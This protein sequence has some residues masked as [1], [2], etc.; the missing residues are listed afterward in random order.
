MSESILWMWDFRTQ[1][2]VLIVLFVFTQGLAAVLCSHGRPGQT[3]PVFRNV[4]EFAMLVPAFICVLLP[5]LFLYGFEMNSFSGNIFPYL[6]IGAIL[7]F[8]IR[9]IRICVLM[10]RELRT[11]LS[12][13]SIKNAVDTL[14]SGVLFCERSGYVLLINAQM[15][16][17]MTVITGKVFRDSNRFYEML[18]AGDVMPGCE[19]NEL[20]NQIVYVLPDDSAWMLTRSEITIKG[21]IYIQITATDIT[22]RWALTEQL[23]RQEEELRQR[24]EEIKDTLANLH[25]LSREKVG[26]RVKM[27]A[28][29]VLGERL[30]L[31]LRAV[32]NRREMDTGMLY[33]L[34]TDFLDEI[35]ASEYRIAPDDALEILK[36]EFALI[37]VE[38]R[39]DG[40]LPG[41]E[42]KSRLS[43]EIIR[44]A[45][46]NAV[47]HGFATKVN[48]HMEDSEAGSCLEITDN[49]HQPTGYKEGGGIGGIRE[50]IK[51]LGGALTI[52]TDPGFILSCSFP[53]LFYKD[54]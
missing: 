6:F 41:D 3:A 13:F 43:L 30:T 16:R 12:A 25:I 50:K 48:I 45:V 53:A 36:Q 34:S 5:G 49:G 14:H 28:H 8:T 24:S 44:E 11:N 7:F 21:K 17:L 39:I 47:R 29:D 20:E 32:H 1:I 37:G 22:E 19:K 52:T 33:S 42:T 27:R 26:I 35:R 18:K 40:T 15:Q 2:A 46:T 54:S 9:S 10:I 51:P 4:F 23:N 38:I 31:L